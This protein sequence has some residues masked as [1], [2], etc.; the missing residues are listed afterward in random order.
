M[1]APL[2]KS[3]GDDVVSSVYSDEESSNRDSKLRNQSGQSSRPTQKVMENGDDDE[4]DDEGADEEELASSEEEFDALSNELE[5]LEEVPSPR[6]NVR[7]TSNNMA[8]G[9][10]TKTTN[11]ADYS[12]RKQN[13]NFSLKPAL[14][15]AGTRGI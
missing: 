5:D 15:I 3:E 9:R 6:A 2:Y 12:S 10:M 13:V 7:V 1:L 14:K 8:A 4:E 11:A